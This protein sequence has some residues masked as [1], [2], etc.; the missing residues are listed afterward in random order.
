MMEVLSTKAEERIERVT[1]SK[2]GEKENN[3]DWYIDRRLRDMVLG[4]FN[5]GRYV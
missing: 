4:R 1:A 3:S 5:E 2:G